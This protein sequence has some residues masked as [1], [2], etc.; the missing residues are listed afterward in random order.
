M[1]TTNDY[2]QFKFISGNRKLNPTNL[3][4]LRDS[5]KK[6]NLLKASPILVS[7]DME[8]IDGQ[9]RLK[10]A[11]ELG[12][13]ISYITLLLEDKKDLLSLTQLLNSNMKIWGSEDYL[14]SHIELGNDEY[15]TLNEFRK[16]Y[17]LTITLALGY[18][19]SGSGYPSPVSKREASLMKDFREGNFKVN[20]LNNAIEHAEKMLD[21]MPYVDDG[22]YKD[23]RFIAAVKIAEKQVTHKRL[24]EKLA[25][26]REKVGRQVSVTAFVRKLEDIY[27]FRNMKKIRFYED[28]E[29]EEKSSSKDSSELGDTNAFAFA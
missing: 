14:M 28:A 27:N 6:K 2:K 15:C 9:H 25:L 12:L 18:L 8:V 17:Q 7:E 5:I 21:F 19:S 22:V 13:E 10:V 4:N 16:K 26:S 24:L 23:R 3:N 1:N 29:E 11:E 20:N